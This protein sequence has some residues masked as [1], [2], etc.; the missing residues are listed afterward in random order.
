MYLDWVSSDCR[1]ATSPG[2]LSTITASFSFLLLIITVPTNLFVCLAITIDPNK[3]LRTQFNCFTFNLALADL[4]VG[5]ITES[6]AVYIHIRQSLDKEFGH[7]DHAMIQKLAHIPYFIA[8]AASVLSISALAMERWLAVSSPFVYRQYFNVKLSVF[9]SVIIWTI[10]LC[11][12]VI[13]I[14]LDYI[15]ENFI[16]VNSALLVTGIV[17]CFACFKIRSTLKQ[18]R[19][20]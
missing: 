11:Y 2:E 3:E 14:W 12:G 18:V 20:K 8:S 1:N 13:N 17:V 15:L 6:L 10:A 19:L 16:F 7:T 9:L 4:L 5:C